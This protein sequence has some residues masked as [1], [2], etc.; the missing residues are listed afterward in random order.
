MSIAAAC[1]PY[2]G[3]YHELCVFLTLCQI[4]SHGCTMGTI[5]TIRFEILNFYSWNL[6]WLEAKRLD[7]YRFMQWSWKESKWSWKNHICPYFD[8][9]ACNFNKN[10]SNGLERKS[11][12]SPFAMW[13]PY[14]RKNGCFLQGNDLTDCLRLGIH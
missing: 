10:R 7:W 4:C 1:L 14:Q 13:K 12:S 6:F 2:C 3:S 8:H 11:R 5:D 9:V